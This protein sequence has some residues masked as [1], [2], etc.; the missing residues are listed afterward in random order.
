FGEAIQHFIAAKKYDQAAAL[1]EAQTHPI[2][3][4]TGQV[5]TLLEW[6]AELPADLFQSRPRLNI[7][8]AWTLISPNQFDAALEH[9]ETTRQMIRGTQDAETSD[10]IGEIAL[11]RGVL[12]E[13]SSRDVAAM[14]EQALLAWDKLPEN[15]L[16]LRCLAAW[17]LGLSYRYDGDTSNAEIYLLRAISLG[18]EAGN[19]YF[20]LV[21]IVDLSAVLAE[22]GR[23]REAYQLLLQTQQDMSATNRQSHP[24]LGHLYIYCS[25]ILL[26]WNQLEEAEKQLSLGIDL[27]AH[28]VAGEV[29]FFGMYTMPYLRLAQGKRKEAIKLARE[30]LDRLGTYPLPYL[31]PI[32][33]SNL[34]PFWIHV[35]DYDR[36]EE[37]LGKCNLELREPICYL[38]EDIYTSL[39]KVLIWQ[40]QP[41]E[42]LKIL[43]DLCSFAESHGRNGKLFYVMALQALAYKQKRMVD[44]ALGKL[45][46][47]LRLGE[48]GGYIRNFVDEGRPMEELLQ[49]GVTRGL[50]KRAGLGIYVN[51]LL[52][53]FRQEG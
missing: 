14:R 8:K 17:L 16:M 3:F 30:C 12:A 39:A 50:W 27:A 38:N 48:L 9:L 34:I 53:I 41:E 26:Q 49:L 24:R 33:K 42:A 44:M 35:D 10:L 25:R 51:S 46:G 37:W 36:I 45:E 32:I 11:M 2:L 43:A 5:Y 31:P 28:D 15:D 13:M 1:I 6:L 7:A 52:K 23:P 4:T 18:R 47:S 19:I 20:T 29:L 40:G 21:S 22:Q